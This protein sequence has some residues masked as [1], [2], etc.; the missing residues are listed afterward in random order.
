MRIGVLALA[1]LFVLVGVGASAEEVSHASDIHLDDRCAPGET[2]K[3]FSEQTGIVLAKPDF[4]GDVQVRYDDG[5]RT[6]SVDLLDRSAVAPGTR[7]RL[8]SWNGDV[9]SVY[10]PANEHRY[11]TVSWPDRWDSTW[12]GCLG[13]GL[14]LLAVVYTPRLARRSFA[15]LRARRLA[16]TGESG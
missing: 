12:I 1:W 9:V 3:C 13:F 4:W 10:D 2:G 16:L 15:K 14:F 8:E 5:R 6:M 11:R 7:V